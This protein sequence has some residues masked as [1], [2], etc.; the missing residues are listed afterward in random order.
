MFKHIGIISKQDDPEIAKPLL[1]LI[2]QLLDLDLEIVADPLSLELVKDHLTLPTEIPPFQCELDL[3]ITIGGDGTMLHA[4][5][6]HSHREIRLLGINMGRLGFLADLPPDEITTTLKN[7]LEGDYIEETRFLLHC[8]VWRERELLWQSAALN[9]A[10]IHKWN[11]ASLIEFDTHVNDRFLHTQRS[12]GIIIST[13][14]G[15]T[16][17]ALAGG[18]PI[19]APTLP[20]ILLVPIC[21]HTLTNRPIVL[22]NSSKIEIRIKTR[23]PGDTRLNCDG[24]DIISLGPGDHVI[25]RKHRHPVHLIHPLKH[26]HFATLRAKLHWGQELC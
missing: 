19:I 21:P 15:S 25:I 20:A 3:I 24:K 18:G 10:V 11:T 26:D 17:Y 16:A 22:D 5:Q 13:P 23:Q 12:D 7:I 9:D 14:T 6:A 4:A 2:Q 1:E 8:E